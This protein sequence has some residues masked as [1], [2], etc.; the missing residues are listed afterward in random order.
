MTLKHN[1]ELGKKI[2]KCIASNYAN[3]IFPKAPNLS[4]DFSTPKLIVEVKSCHIHTKDRKNLT[5]IG[6]Y[7]IH[8]NSHEALKRIAE[9]QHKTPVYVFVIL[10]KDDEIADSKELPYDP[11]NVLLNCVPLLK[12]GD[13]VFSL[14]HIFWKW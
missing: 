3:S 6:R 12:R 8:K 2:E 9:E 13:Y 11:I 5:R 10:N 1:E 14:Q 7:Y 4:Y